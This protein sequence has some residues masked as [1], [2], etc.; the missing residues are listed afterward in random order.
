VEKVRL[1]ILLVDDH[2]LLREGLT[3]LLH[4]EPDLEIVGEAQDGLM[5]IEKARE[6]QPDVILMDISMPR[7]N[8]IEATRAIS[9]ELPKINIIGLSMHEKE[10]MAAAMREAGAVNYL[11]KDTPS[12]LLVDAIRVAGRRALGLSV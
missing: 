1:R 2:K 9:R 6:L 11:P 3:G 12:T 10:D 4:D 8:G 5:A 7:M